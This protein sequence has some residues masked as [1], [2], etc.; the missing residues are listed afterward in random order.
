MA[1]CFVATVMKDREGQ[2]RRLHKRVD[3]C[4][5][6]I[7]DPIRDD[8]QDVILEKKTKVYS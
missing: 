7:D 4:L 6:I 2:V 8:E 5:H 1:R 3:R